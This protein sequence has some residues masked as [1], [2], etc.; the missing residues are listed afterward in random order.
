MR[1]STYPKGRTTSLYPEEATA[2][3]AQGKT[4]R[5]VHRRHMSWRWIDR[6]DTMAQRVAWERLAMQQRVV[7]RC[8]RRSRQIQNHTSQ[9]TRIRW[10]THAQRNAQAIIHTVGS[11]HSPAAARAVE[12]ALRIYWIRRTRRKLKM[13]ALA[14]SDQHHLERRHRRIA[15]RAID[16]PRETSHTTKN[17]HG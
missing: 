6:M 11:S 7:A 4:V 10:T 1:N 17:N 15:T 3:S 8:T 14:W 13:T 16:V 2:R 9:R 12:A 5:R